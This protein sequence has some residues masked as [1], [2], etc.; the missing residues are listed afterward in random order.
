MLDDSTIKMPE[1][2]GFRSQVARLAV[3]LFALRSYYVEKRTSKPSVVV[4]WL[5][6]T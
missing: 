1:Y 5:E 6:P 3:V 2:L 4:I